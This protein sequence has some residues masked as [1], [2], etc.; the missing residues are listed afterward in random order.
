MTLDSSAGTGWYS[1]LSHHLKILVRAGLL[2][3]ERRGTWSWY[4]VQSGPLDL[5]S[6]LLQP[7]GPF[8]DNPEAMPRSD[9]D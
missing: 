5:M 6:T 4:S 1:W 9:C 3:R 2:A 7:G 8:R